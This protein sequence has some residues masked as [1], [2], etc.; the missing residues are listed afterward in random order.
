MSGSSDDQKSES[1]M[2][3]SSAKCFKERINLSQSPPSSL[4]SV[5]VDGEEMAQM[6]CTQPQSKQSLVSSENLIT[7][8]I[9]CF[10]PLADLSEV[11][12]PESPTQSQL[13]LTSVAPSL[14][15]EM[16]LPPPSP[17][18]TISHKAPQPSVKP[19]N[20]L[21]SASLQKPLE[22]Q[23]FVE[24]ATAATTAKDEQQVQLTHEGAVGEDTMHGV[25]TEKGTNCKER[26]SARKSPQL[27]RNRHAERL[28]TGGGKE[29][30]GSKISYWRD[31]EKKHLKDSKNEWKRQKKVHGPIQ[32]A[33]LSEGNK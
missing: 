13:Q 30:H 5:R 19:A 2:R 10:T 1:Q 12:H 4:N 14:L 25:V 24:S 18:T 7:T 28:I 20:I 16:E 23:A 27:A 15:V 3:N 6:S 26:L 32:D 9:E 33:C 11:Y 17:D 21:D 29:M 31:K 22:K 8:N